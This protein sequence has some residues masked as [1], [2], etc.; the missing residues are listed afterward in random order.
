MLANRNVPGVIKWRL[1]EFAKMSR[2]KF[3]T[4]VDKSVISSN[5]ETRGWTLSSPDDDWNF[6][7]ASVQSVR[8]I[9]NSDTGYRLSDNQIVNHFPN[10]FELTRKDMMV[11]NIK[12]YRRDLER[13]GS[14]LAARDECGRYIYLDFIPKNSKETLLPHG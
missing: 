3:A 13:E 4:D 11:K 14:P 5:C 7:W 2:L 10:H 12:R 8:T 1:Y 6:F 9:F